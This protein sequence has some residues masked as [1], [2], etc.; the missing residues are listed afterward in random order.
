MARLDRFYVFLESPLSYKKILEYSIK[1]DHTRSDHASVSLVLELSSPDARPS[2]WIMSSRYLD[3]VAPEIRR[4]WRDAPVAS[5]FFSK[6]KRV[7]R[8]YRKYCINC[9][10]QFHL[11]EQS[12][13]SELQLKSALLQSQPSSGTLQEEVLQ[14]RS[15]LASFD[16][17]KI[18]G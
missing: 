16:N 4:I 13:C 15:Q 1:S 8:F 5:T 3:D 2:R 6:L 18:E 7:T 9:A 11:K 17:V 10:R 12:I 14:L